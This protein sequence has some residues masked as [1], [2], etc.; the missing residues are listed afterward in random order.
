MDAHNRRVD[1]LNG[2]MMGSSQGV[3]D[4]VPYT[5]PTPANEASTVG[6]TLFW[7]A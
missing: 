4:A 1:H 3:H 7:R 6:Q 5:S 2:C